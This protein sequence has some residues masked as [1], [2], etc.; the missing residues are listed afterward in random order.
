M[1]AEDIIPNK[2]KIK[3]V[4]NYIVKSKPEDNKIIVTGKELIE[5]FGYEFLKDSLVVTLDYNI[6]PLSGNYKVDEFWG[7]SIRIDVAAKRGH[8]KASVKELTNILV[9]AFDDY[10]KVINRKHQEYNQL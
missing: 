3:K 2:E 6:Q 8:N 10:I 1:K 7:N 9:D 5:K 4:I